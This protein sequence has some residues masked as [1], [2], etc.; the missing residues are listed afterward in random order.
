MRVAVLAS[1][2]GSNLRALARAVDAGRCAVELVGLV[3]DRSSAEALAFAASRDMK[4]RLVRPRDHEHRAAWDAALA[5]AVDSL[6]PELVVLAGFMRLLGPAMLEAFADRVVNVH[7]SL[8][9]AFPGMHAPQQALD[10]G[11]R[12]TGCTVHLVDE[13]VDTGRILAQGAV[14]VRPGDDA[15]RLHA[16]IQRLE[17]R[18]LPDVVHALAQGTLD[19]IEPCFEKG[20]DPSP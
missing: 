1:G 15:A 13:G 3:S 16:R 17:H 12:I 5:R 11:V 10:A 2:R 8:L 6:E 19:A 20:E 4:T 9:P 14:P 7:P 18:L